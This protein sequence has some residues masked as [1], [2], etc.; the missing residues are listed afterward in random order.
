MT[1]NAKTDR[2]S[3]RN[4]VAGAAA[5]VA[6]IPMAGAGRSARGQDMPMLTADDP[7]AVALKYVPDASQADQALR[8]SDERFCRNCALF[9]GDEGAEAAPCS[10][11]PGKLVAAGGWCS[12][13]APKPGS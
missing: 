13:W 6:A 9:A 4:F 1:D 10:I 5:A 7:T 12:V 8:Q 11:F 2:L 3:R